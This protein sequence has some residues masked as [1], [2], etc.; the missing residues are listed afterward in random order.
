MRS[1]FRKIVV[2]TGL[3]LFEVAGFP[4]YAQDIATAVITPEQLEKIHKSNDE[5]LA[6]HSEAG[7]SHPPK[8][9]LDLKKL[10]G[11]VRDK[12]DFYNSDH[13]RL[14]CT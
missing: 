5:C 1:L 14:A 12:V 6:C 8:E 3:I 10:R 9:G 13:Q 2:V 7:I 11:L 4:V